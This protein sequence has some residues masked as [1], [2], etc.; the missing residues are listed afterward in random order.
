M[1]ELKK[2]FLYVP[3]QYKQEVKSKGAKWNNESKQWYIY[4]DNDH[5][6]ML[7]DMFHEDN[8]TTN[9]HGIHLKSNLTTKRSR[10]EFAKA[11]RKHYK[12]IR[13][14]WIRKNGNEDGL[15]EYMSENKFSI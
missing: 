3:Y 4:K 11:E 12:T 9:F 13:K 10:K 15:G 1:T 14:Q 5:R 8:F 7:V 6:R 2:L